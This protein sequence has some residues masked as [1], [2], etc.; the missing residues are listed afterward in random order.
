MSAVI[1]PAAV[2]VYGV[3]RVCAAWAFPRAS[4]YAA[5]QPAGADPGV[6]GKRGPKTTLDDAALLALIHADLATTS[7]H[8]E[9]HRKVFARL[10][11]VA[12][13]RVG[14]NRI[15]R[16]MRQHR[17][18]SPHRSRPVPAKAHD[19]RIT[20]GRAPCALGHRW[21]KNVDRRRRLAVAVQRPRTLERRVPR[22]PRLQ[23]RGPLRRL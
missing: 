1:S 16:L 22:P 12:G 19:G 7:F 6:P 9:G 11:Y 13:H 15:L 20:T 21:R 14:R 4:Y 23:T 18:L 5:V 3:Q 8:G 17:L 2:R 10:R